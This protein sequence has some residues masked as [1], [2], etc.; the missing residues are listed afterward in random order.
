MNA[1]ILRRLG[2]PQEITY[3]ALPSGTTV[4]IDGTIRTILR[5]ETADGPESEPWR[6]FLAMHG[7]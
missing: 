1:V 5:D 6:S 3:L 7:I 2:G 4:G